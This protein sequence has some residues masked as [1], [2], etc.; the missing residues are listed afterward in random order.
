LRSNVGAGKKPSSLRT[1]PCF[2][3]L[4]IQTLV[5]SILDNEFSVHE[6]VYHVTR[7]TRVDKPR[8][9][10]PA[11][12]GV[13]T[14]D[15]NHRQVRALSGLNRAH[16]GVDAQRAGAVDGR[17]A[18]RTFRRKCAGPRAHLCEQGGMPQLGPPIQVVV[19]G[20]AV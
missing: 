15:P 12:L 2:D 4:D 13:G 7:A 6:N 16:E 10:V 8:K 5:L 3:T 20:R 18:Q 14:V 9:D 17:Q 1:R 19:A 11:R